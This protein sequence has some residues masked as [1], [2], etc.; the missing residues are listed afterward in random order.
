MGLFQIIA[1]AI[2]VMISLIDG[3]DVLTIAFVAPSLAEQWHIMPEQL[4]LLFSAGLAGMIIGALFI[5]PLADKLG[6]RFII[7]SCLTI[8]TVGMFLSGLSSNHI[9]LIITRIFTGIGM[10]AILPGIN[11][12]VAEYSSNR[13]RALAISIMA[14]G[15]TVGTVV[16][17][18]ISI[19]L[20]KYLGWQY[21]FFFGSAF[22]FLMLPI[23][24]FNIPESLDFL[25]T[26]EANGKSLAKLNYV[27]KK[28][29][30][31]LCQEFPS[32]VTTNQKTSLKLLFTPRMFRA[33]VL[34]CIS[35]FMLM[36]SLYFLM[37]WTPKIF[38]DLGYSK[39]LSIMGS[40]VMNI[41]GIAGGLALGWFSRQYSVQKITALLTLIGFI[42]VVAFGF[43]SNILPILFVIIGLIG[44]TVLG[45][46][47]GLYATAP[48]VFPPE[49]RA[50]GTG[51]VLGLAR[52]GATLG[53]YIAGLLIAVELPRGYYFLILALP[54]LV[55]S[56]CVFA[57]RPYRNN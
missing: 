26:K 45:A 14:V 12:V 29:H 40:L 30:I 5:A 7:L 2:C 9:E 15:Y 52:F 44:F 39:D 23:A 42:A 54:L 22:S 47:A 25:L 48:A 43:S 41:S 38:V 16:G 3:F 36:C 20:I 49:V 10:G 32:A 28:L 17:G 4:G 55:S 19:Y 50:T 35:N 53:P 11:T 24:W 33:T 46:M 1:V 18:V 34:L 31:P 8:L 57:I 51:I 13:Y 27:L 6:R 21:V 37:N 56:S